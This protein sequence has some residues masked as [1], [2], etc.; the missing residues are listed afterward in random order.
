MKKVLCFGSF[1]VLHP[2]HIYYLREAKKLGDYLVV[3]VARDQTIRE[4][5]GKLPKYDESQRLQQ[6]SAVPFV[7]K[8]VLGY[9]GDKYKIVEETDPEVICLGYDQKS[10]T[11][12]LEE[13]LR[14]RGLHPH[15]YR[16]KPYKEDTYKSSKL[17]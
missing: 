13:Q 8:A 1:D 14:Q 12:N 9:D 10:F 7:D 5:K 3:V 17:K 2:G 11:Y 6:V 16:M 4:V 15:I